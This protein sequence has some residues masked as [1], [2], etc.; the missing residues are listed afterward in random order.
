MT[1]RPGGCN[2]PSRWTF[3]PWPGGLASTA[4]RRGL[5]VAEVPA[6]ISRSVHR[7]LADHPPLQQAL[8]QLL[9]SERPGALGGGVRGGPGGGLAAARPRR[10]PRTGPADLAAGALALDRLQSLAF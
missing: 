9:R 8:T 2:P 6:A 10:S 1:C 5:A 7:L 3:R 4:R